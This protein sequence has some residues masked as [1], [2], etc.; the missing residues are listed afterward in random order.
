MLECEEV[1]EEYRSDLSNESE[2]SDMVSFKKVEFHIHP[3]QDDGNFK[4]QASYLPSQEPRL[5]QRKLKTIFSFRELPINEALSY[6]SKKK[7]EAHSLEK[8][9]NNTAEATILSLAQQFK[10]QAKQVKISKGISKLQSYKR[11]NNDLDPSNREFPYPD[12]GFE[13]DLNYGHISSIWA[14]ISDH[15]SPH[16][17]YER[18][19]N[20]IKRRT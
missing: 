17:K 8:K 1:E 7:S 20:F 11:D 14:L 12:F 15:I 4:R 18:F 5:N 19:S 3:P 16:P 2:R 6:R 10:L 9:T 13:D